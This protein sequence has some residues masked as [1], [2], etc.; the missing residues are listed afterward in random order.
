MNYPPTPTRQN[1]SVGRAAHPTTKSPPS[2]PTSGKITLPSPMTR[3]MRNHDPAGSPVRG[4]HGA[5]GFARQR[6]TPMP[7]T[8][9]IS[10][11]TSTRGRKGCN[12]NRS[13]S[14]RLC[15][16]SPSCEMH[17]KPLS[18]S[19]KLQKGPNCGFR[20]TSRAHSPCK[21]FWNASLQTQTTQ[22]R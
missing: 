13:W 10:A 19:R 11:F 3:K 14:S 7:A 12:G 20:G 16:I 15:S 18:V 2:L 4:R 1:T 17:G 5:V 8:W 21:A 9:I 22:R 6:Y